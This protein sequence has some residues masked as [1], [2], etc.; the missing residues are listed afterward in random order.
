MPERDRSEDEGLDLALAAELQSVLLPAQCPTDCPHH[1]AAA[2][3]RMCGSVGGDFYDFI[4]PNE[5][6]IVILIGDVVGHGVRAALVM[7][8]IMGYLHSRREML[9]RPH[10]VITM[11]N[12]MLLDLGERIGKALPCSMFYTVM[13]AP[14]GASF[15]VNTGHPAPL[16][17]DQGKSLALEGDP[18]N[19]LLGIEEFDPVEGCHS[20]TAG[21]RLVLYTDGV[22]EARGPGDAKFGESRFHEVLDAHSEDSPDRCTEA[23]FAA[24]DEFRGNLKQLDDETIVVVDRV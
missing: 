12:R 11:L 10:H 9:T 4:R 20:F 15:F 1:L 13:D 22:T 6:Q 16:I 2:R 21:Q 24:I 17:Y 18:R 14:T 3:N 8:R 19:M 7:A 23:V 5:E